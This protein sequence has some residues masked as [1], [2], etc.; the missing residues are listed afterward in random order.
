M[1]FGWHWSVGVLRFHI[2]LIDI[3]V[4]FYL[5]KKREI[6]VPKNG[7]WKIICSLLKVTILNPPTKHFRELCYQEIHALNNIKI[8]GNKQCMSSQYPCLAGLLCVFKIKPTKY[9]T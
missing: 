8:F 3:L 6:S 4:A 7:K 5:I 9:S 1:G 2:C